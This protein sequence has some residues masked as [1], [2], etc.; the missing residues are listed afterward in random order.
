MGHT[1]PVWPNEVNLR[2]YKPDVRVGD[3]ELNELIGL[4]LQAQKP[5]LY[6]GGGIISGEAHAELLEFAER[7][8]IP[9]ATTLMGVGCFPETHPLSLKWLGMHGTVYANNAV[10]EADLL[11]AFGV[12]FDDRVTGKLEAFCEHGTIVHLEIDDS[13]INKNKFVKLPMLG[14][15][16]DALKRAN[17]LLDK[18]GYDRVS[19]GQF[20]RYA[21]WR[22]QIVEWKRDFPFYYEDT[23]DAIQPQYVIEQLYKLTKGEAI[24]TTGVGQHQ[25]WA[26]QFY[27]FKEPRTWVS[28]LGLGSMGY[29]YPSAHRREDGAAGQGGDRYRRRR[30]V[31]DE[32]P[33]AGLRAG[34]RHRG[35]GARAEQPAPRHGGAMGGPLFQIEPGPHLP[36]R[37]SRTRSARCRT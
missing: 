10:N 23:E 11:L 26:A 35:Q 2:G 1:Q 32:H 33:G 19:D 27:H 6:V 24:I 12:R 25:M 3:A 34:G 8:Q 36:R 28:S 20:T 31:C 7:T 15:V 14:D 18:A 37:L 22:A 13:E 5:M 4:I 16:K 21:P 9:V 17:A 30:F 29:G